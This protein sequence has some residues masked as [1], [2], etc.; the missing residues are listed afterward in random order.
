MFIIKQYEQHL[1]MQFDIRYPTLTFLGA[2]LFR[3][4]SSQVVFFTQLISMYKL[5]KISDNVFIAS[6]FF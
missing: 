2:N 3:M 6:S 4:S 1:G 5:Y